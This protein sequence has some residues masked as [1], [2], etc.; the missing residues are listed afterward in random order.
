MIDIEIH[1]LIYPRSGF[2]SVQWNFPTGDTLETRKRAPM[3]WCAPS[4]KV[5]AVGVTSWNLHLGNSVGTRKSDP[6]YIIDTQMFEK[7]SSI[8]VPP[9]TFFLSLSF[10]WKNLTLNCLNW[11]GFYFLFSFKFCSLNSVSISNDSSLLSG[12][13]EDSSVRVWSLTPK[14]L[15]MLKSPSEL[16]LID[17]EAG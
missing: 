9:K 6:L 14:K 17:K 4:L 5:T 11:L 2:I 16:A 10:L 8:V 3:N 13:F 12:G 1:Q 15:R 7:T